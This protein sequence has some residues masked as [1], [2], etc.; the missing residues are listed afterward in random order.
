MPHAEISALFT[1]KWVTEHPVTK[2]YIGSGIFVEML[3]E[4]WLRDVR[5][6][7]PR[8]QAREQI[9][10]NGQYTH[11]FFSE[12]KP[13]AKTSNDDLGVQKEKE[14]I[15]KAIVLSRLVK[16]TAIAYDSVWVTS[17]YSEKEVKHYHHNQV[18]NNLNVAFVIPG[19]EDWNTITTENAQQMGQLWD[20]FLF[21]FDNELRYR[22]VVRAIKTS[23][24]ACSVY[25]AE[26]CHTIMHAAL[27]SL[28]CTHYRH[29]KAQVTQRLPQLVPFIRP[30]E[31]ESIYKLCAGFKHAA[32]AMLQD[33]SSISGNLAAGDQER[34][35]AVRLLRQALRD[36]LVR[37]LT[38]RA[39]ADLLSDKDLLR[40]SYP[41]FDR[42]G[43]LL[44]NV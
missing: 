41:V 16:P 23:E 12:C 11:R 35:N 7:C 25:F 6:Q 32:E 27:E 15:R 21:L 30:D 22:R 28:I 39:F 18:M 37:A 29:N 2:A 43:K 5:N 34:V 1:L 26:M 24:I 4:E 3:S 14:L 33:P 17:R 19:F 44:V 8:I 38:D 40:R 31:A 42:K 13:E 9:E 36:L 10:W 20:S